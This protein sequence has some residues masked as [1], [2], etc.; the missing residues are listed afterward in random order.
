MSETRLYP[1]MSRDEKTSF[2]PYSAFDIPADLR[3]LSGRYDVEA[4][5]RRCRN[6]RYAEEWLMMMLG[7]WVAT[8]PELPVKTGLG[9]V[10][11]ETAQAADALGRRL[12]ELRCGRVVV[13]ASESANAGF[14]A[15]IQ[16]VSEPERPDLTIEKLAGPFDVL[17][18]HLVDVYEETM[19]ETD[20]ICDAPTIELLDDIVRKRRR[21]IRWGREVLDRLCETDA[22]RERRRVRV[23]GLNAELVRSGGVTGTLSEERGVLN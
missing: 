17:M 16:S 18:P 22:L 14:A 9:K 5:A 13:D 15:F 6:F 8:I 10:I 23:E 11:W 21:H 7:G 19:R 20:Q 3:E 12:P 1:G 2:A 4:M